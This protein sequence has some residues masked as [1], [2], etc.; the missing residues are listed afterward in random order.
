[1]KASNRK[2][3]NK[4]SGNSAQLNRKK[5]DHLLTYQ[6]NRPDSSTTSQYQNAADQYNQTQQPN[7]LKKLDQQ[8]YNSK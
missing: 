1:M 8:V 2:K 4:I 7:P 5:G 6:D 3:S